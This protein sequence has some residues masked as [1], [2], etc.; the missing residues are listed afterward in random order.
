MRFLYI[1]PGGYK[2]LLL[3]PEPS[4]RPYVLRIYIHQKHKKSVQIIQGR[5][6]Y[7]QTKDFQEGPTRTNLAANSAPLKLWA[8]TKPDIWILE[9]PTH[10]I[11]NKDTIAHA[12]RK[13]TVSGW[14]NDIE[15]KKE[16]WIWSYL[17]CP[18]RPNKS[19]WYPHI[20]VAIAFLQSQLTNHSAAPG[21]FADEY[22][23]IMGI[24]LSCG[25]Y[26]K[27]EIRQYS[28]WSKRLNFKVLK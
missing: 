11:L 8:P 23:S 20:S 15:R 2:H 24:V 19:H 4:R 14:Y 12:S 17:Q 21:G 1:G 22:Y 28:N 10:N 13:L 7:R 27:Y 3:V 16:L 26:L 5:Q 25:Q 9:E 6:H 18:L